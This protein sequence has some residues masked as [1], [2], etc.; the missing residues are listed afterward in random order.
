M[1][2]EFVKT[3][4]AK[5]FDLK[6]EAAQ[7]RGAR[8]SGLVI[9][10]GRPGD[11]KTRTME[12][13]AATVGAVMVTAQVDWTPHRMMVEL[14]EKLGVT[15]VKGFDRLIGKMIAKD[16][17][18]II[19]DE[20]GF[21]LDRKAA[22]LEKLRGITDSTSTLLVLVFMERDIHRLES[23]QVLQLHSRVTNKCAFKK[24]SLED[25]AAACL[26]LSEV[27]FAPDLAEHVFRQTDGS[28]RMAVNAIAR[29]EIVAKGRAEALR[30]TPV[31]IADI[32]GVELFHVLGQ[33]SRKSAQA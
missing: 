12:A 30:H 19:V 6:V 20:A 10:T 33:A 22:C 29:I 7:Q 8:E 31:Q 14:A 27:P 18:S 4:N 25:I 15:P 23:P 26:Q 16:K 24:N 5:L 9:V 11:G 13:W 21:C 1:K 17:I 28:M 32:K 2:R 3:S